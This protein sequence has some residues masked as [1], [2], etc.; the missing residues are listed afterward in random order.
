[1]EQLDKI[2]NSYD[3]MISYQWTGI[4]DK[5]RIKNL[6]K[7]L[8]YFNSKNKEVFC[9][10]QFLDFFDFNNMG[11]DDNYNFCLSAQARAKNILFFINAKNE[12]KGMKKELEFS[13]R[14]NQNRIL[15][16]KKDCLNLEWVKSFKKESKKIY[17]FNDFK[18]FILDFN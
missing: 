11:S 7:I 1:M 16:I 6:K 14:N 17:V 15:L 4:S 2:K 10:D 8:Q 3:W 13:I 12:S 9:S 18:D 5:D